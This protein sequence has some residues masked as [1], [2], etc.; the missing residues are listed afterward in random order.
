MATE[1]VFS[2]TSPVVY[3]VSLVPAKWQWVLALNPMAGII[4][5]YRSAIFGKPWNGLTL[6]VSGGMTVGVFV[7]GLF[8]F[9]RTE[10]RF[11]DIA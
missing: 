11:A 8:Y 9:R 5:G 7:L 10:R 1:S 3:P 6:S 2:I 4:D